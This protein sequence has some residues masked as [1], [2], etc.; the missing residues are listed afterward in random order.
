M[1]INHNINAMFAWKQM[2]VAEKRMGR[3]I[4]RMTT[5]LRINRASDDPAGLAISEKM[6]G[7]IRGLHQASRNA[8]DGISMLQTAEGVLN[9]TH[10]MLQR[11][12][13]LAVQ[14]SN[15]TLCQEDRD[16]LSK[17]FEELKKEISRS[18][19]DSEFNKN[20]LLNKDN[21]S[22]TLQVGPNAGQSMVITFES[23]TSHSLNLDGVNIKTQQDA[24]DAIKK[25]QEAVGKTSS[26]RG[27]LGAYESRLEHVV[28]INDNTAENLEAAESR[29]R[30]A[31]IAKEMM[32][33]TKNS[34]LFQVA[35]AMLAQANQQ[36]KNVLEL[37][38]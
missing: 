14:A 4:E 37:L 28:S 1:I 30:D 25:L 27:S 9:E 38:K 34:I 23:M 10:S 13:E 6:R 36:A 7:Q 16:A 12:N 20:H 26:L 18:A 17:E 29:I 32:D 24:S 21:N 2:S 11:M 3:A 31:D 22:V 19:N 33:Y 35:Q 15:G 8:Q 5:G